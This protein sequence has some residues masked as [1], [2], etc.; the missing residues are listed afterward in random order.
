ML[1]SADM[2]PS[3]FYPVPVFPDLL[4]NKVDETLADDLV[5]RRNASFL[6]YL[7]PEL[8]S[9]NPWMLIG[10]IQA[11]IQ[12]P[13]EAWVYHD[14]ETLQH[15]FLAGRFEA[16]FNSNCVMVRGSDFGK[17]VS[18]QEEL[19]YQRDIIGYPRARLLLE[20]QYVL[21]EYLRVL[22]KI[23]YEE[24]SQGR[25]TG[26][27]E[28]QAAVSS[29]TAFKRSGG[30][31]IWSKFMFQPYSEPASFDIE[32]LISLAQEN[33]DNLKDHIRLMQSEPVYLK[34]CIVNH[35]ESNIADHLHHLGRASMIMVMLSYDFCGY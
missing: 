30:L 11:R 15:N 8:M 28:W 22:V 3:I 25:A 20:G 13:P 34:R 1:I 31:A 19:A 2:N 12:Y 5:K 9:T 17:L 10:L 14:N 23:M 18:F 7:C 6:L 32:Y 4:R 16:S 21:Y 24:C 33:C 35:R 26:S 29:S 27:D